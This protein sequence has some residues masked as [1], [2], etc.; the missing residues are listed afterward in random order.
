MQKYVLNLVVILL[1]TYCSLANALGVGGLTVNTALNEPLDATIALRNSGDVRVGEISVRLAS[2]ADFEATGIEYLTFLSGLNFE[3]KGDKNNRPISINVSSRVPVIEPYVN[4]LIEL[5]WPNGRIL[6]E[7]TVLLDPVFGDTNLNAGTRTI[8]EQISVAQAPQTVYKPSAKQNAPSGNRLSRTGDSASS[9]TVLANDTLWEIAVEHKPQGTSVHQAM[10]AIKDANPDAF[11]N[12][13]INRLKAG[14]VLRVPSANEIQRF[15]RQE[16][17]DATRRDVALWSGDQSVKKTTG[18]STYQAEN[19]GELRLAGAEDGDTGFASLEEQDALNSANEEL[20]DRVNDLESQLQDLNKLL[21]LKNSQLALLQQ[22]TENIDNSKVAD[23]A[24]SIEKVNQALNTTNDDLSALEEKKV[25]AELESPVVDDE[26]IASTLAAKQPLKSSAPVTLLPELPIWQQPLAQLGALFLLLLLLLLVYVLR[27][28]SKAD[29]L[30]VD[31]EDILLSVSEESDV[32]DEEFIALPD[33]EENDLATYEARFESESYT[34]AIADLESAVES[35]AHRADLRLL[36]LKLSAKEGDKDRFV[37]HFRSLEAIG[38]EKDVDAARRIL[39][40]ITGSNEW[41]SVDVEE[42]LVDDSDDFF[43]EIVHEEELTDEIEALLMASEGATSLDQQD[44][45]DFDVGEEGQ[46]IQS[47]DE[48]HA[49]LGGLEPVDEDV[50]KVVDEVKTELTETMIIP[51]ETKAA[52]PDALE[53]KEDE[54]DE[55]EFDLGDELESFTDLSVKTTEMTADSIDDGLEFENTISIDK[56]ELDTTTDNHEDDEMS[57]DEI[58]MDTLSISADDTGLEVQ[59]SEIELPADESLSSDDDILDFDIDSLSDDTSVDEINLSETSIDDIADEALDIDVS[60]D[61]LDD[62]SLSIDELIG[63]DD[64]AL[65]IDDLLN[66]ESDDPSDSEPS[67][68]NVLD[69]ADFAEDDD[70][71]LD[72]FDLSADLDTSADDE[73]ETF[74]EEDGSDNTSDFDDFAGFLEDMDEESIAGTD[75]IQ[76]K[77]DLAEAYIEMDDFDGARD[78]L[79]EVVN[80][81][82][83][84]QQA[85]ARNMLDKISG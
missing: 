79:T 41:L 16:A 28:R 38:Q 39:S 76:T 17:L 23:I 70:L 37:S 65:D 6:K 84:A 64:S 31:D 61:N 51:P 58:S 44:F 63:D 30:I 7:Y 9:V 29:E 32:D 10:H 26:K 45:E 83:V 82:D 85:E 25:V 11:F 27:N 22:Q 14:Y 24:E 67:D 2:V 40:S 60:M 73:L 4:F 47:L 21:E 52:G 3:I 66:L 34:E 54:S 50:E 18:S 81:G 71:E 48:L 72:S 53:N 5:S 19:Q 55:L 46:D 36:L 1:G 69:L 42:T 33:E 78:A 59:G 56:T 43:R 57:M 62:E 35:Q 15:G 8:A 77:L 74:V 68:E 13:N 75:A 80:E 20:A 12:N 49:S